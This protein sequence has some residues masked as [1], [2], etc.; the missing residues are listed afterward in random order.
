MGRGSSS[1]SNTNRRRFAHQRP[2]TPPGATTDRSYQVITIGT[3]TFAGTTMR[4]FR[5]TADGRTGWIE[6]STTVVES[7]SAGC[8]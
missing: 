8:P 5:V 6:D 4:W 2:Q 7:R 1:R 3:S